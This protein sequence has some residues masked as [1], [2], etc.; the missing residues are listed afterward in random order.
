MT[1][2]PQTAVLVTLGAVLGTGLTIAAVAL[3][4]FGGDAAFLERQ[5]KAAPTRAGDIERLLLTTPSPFAPHRRDAVEARCTTRGSGE[6]RNPWRCSVAYRSGPKAR[7]RLNIRYDGSFKA[8]HL[9][10]SGA[11]V[12]CCVALTPA[13]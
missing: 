11:V 1:S 10:G 5:R 2:R 6:L 9:D 12:A 4:A 7:F 13:E 8:D 3:G